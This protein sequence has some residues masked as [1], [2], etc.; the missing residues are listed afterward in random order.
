MG[1]DPH[2]KET[3]DMNGLSWGL[4][5]WS[6]GLPR[7]ADFSRPATLSRYDRPLCMMDGV[8]VSR[9]FF[10][11]FLSLRCASPSAS[12]PQEPPLLDAF[13]SVGLRR[14]RM[15]EN[16][17]DLCFSPSTPVELGFATSWSREEI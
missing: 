7:R 1:K 14:M 2:E 5:T 4:L 6:L 12:Y 11:F 8:R 9:L 13:H 15:E 3:Q 17:P 10:F 16:N